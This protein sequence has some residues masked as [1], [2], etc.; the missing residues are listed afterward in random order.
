MSKKKPFS[1]LARWS[2]CVPLVVACQVHALSPYSD[3]P[4]FLGG[5]IQPNVMFTLDD[6]GSMQWDAMPDNVT[7]FAY[8]YPRPVGLY[9]GADYS[10]YVPNFDPTNWYNAKMRSSYNNKIYYN[11]AVTYTPWA[12]SGGALWANAVTTCAPHNPQLPGLG[13]RDLT[14]SQTVNLS[15]SSWWYG[16]AG[17]YQGN[18]TFTPAVYYR[19]NS[20]SVN[21]AGSY[22]EVKIT[23]ATASYT[24]DGRATRTDCTAGTC[25]YA[26]EIQNFANWYTYYRSRILLARA[27]VG[28]AFSAQGGNMRV[29]FAAINKGNT[30]VDGVANTS[31]VISGVRPFTLGSADR[32]AFFTSLYGH[33]IPTSGT[34]LRTALK[35]VGGY[36]ERTDDQGPWGETPGS[37]GGTQHE[38]RQSYNILMTDGYWND[39]ES[40]VGNADGT[41]GSTIT[42]HSSPASPANYT[43]SAVAPFTDGYSNTLADYAMDYWKRDLRTGL[44]NKVPTN[45]DDPAFW[46]HMVTFTAGLGVSGTLVAPLPAAPAWPDPTLGD[47]QKLDDLWHAA[48]NGHGE[49]FSAAEPQAFAAGLSSALSTI[50]ARTGSASAV[51]TN[52]TKLDAN[53]RTYQA[54]FNSGDWSGQLLAYPIDI[55]G[56]FGSLDW[57]AGVVVNSIAPSLRVILT[58]GASDGVEFQYANLTAAQQT[59]LNKNASGTTDGCG[60]ER[61]AYLRGDAVNEGSGTFTC[62]ST[63]VINKLRSRPTSKLGDIVNSGP[64]YVG[65]PSA[66]YSDV[67]HPGY[68]AFSGASGY[69]SRT[70]MIYVG[71][72][73][74]SLHAFNACVSGVTPGCVAADEGKELLAYVPNMVYANLSRLTDTSYNASHRYFVDG[75][76]MVADADT[77]IAGTPAWKSVLVGSMNGGGQGYFA[78]NVTNPIDTTKSAPTFAAANAAS[79][80][81]WEFTNADDADMGYSHNLPPSD[82]FTAQSTQIVKMKNG[83][84]AVIVGNGYQSA[85]GKAVLYVLFIK[86]GEDGVWTLGTDYI[87]LVADPGTGNGLSTPVPFDADGDGLADVIYAGDLKGNMWKFDV[88]S[89]TVASWNVALGGTP[90]FAAGSSNP[91]TSPPVVTLH[92][93]GGNLVLFGTGKYL[94]TSDVTDTSVR[95]LYGVWDDPVTPFATV[96]AS[97]L[98]TQTMTISG[99]GRLTTANPVNYST[100]SPVVNGWKMAFAVGGE[101]LTTIPSLEDGVFLLNSII[102]SSSPCDTGG[103]GKVYALNYLTGSILASPAFDTDGDGDV[104]ASDGVYAGWEIGFVPGGVTRISGTSKDVLVYSKSDGTLGK[105]AIPPKDA[106]LR[107]RIH[108]RELVQ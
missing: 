26:Q 46:Q 50:T 23:S 8:L 103:T 38:C 62:A 89:T 70:P 44:N 79:L 39:G 95:T 12:Q 58:K 69:S 53:G 71:A 10:N 13:C 4:L 55:F 107:G 20:G 5:N 29:G 88:S 1:R 11:P 105:I 108:W 101:R 9:G 42:N 3:N 18:H 57:D 59:E 54:K 75:S 82:P 40:G 47:P 106:G 56:N 77:G 52:S 31:V 22:T 41:A 35:K 60:P 37:A 30:T 34:P 21:S 85:N 14:V 66:G 51:A 84:W 17:W 32:N 36:Y 24:G 87:K 27:G 72:N 49:F 80:L 81:L 68:E 6:S 86:E 97:D 45:P 2:A 92:P 28:R 93:N 73:D 67:D 63:T 65:E 48:V 100:T 15:G 7:Y 61:V 90:L 94:E 16:T 25:T 102:P 78:L 98:I 99:Q 91:I 19:Y 74:G 43:Y 104:D 76:P 33:V 96:P 83:K 64:A